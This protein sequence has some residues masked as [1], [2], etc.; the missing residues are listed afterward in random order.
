MEFPP[1]Y[2]SLN[3]YGALSRF[4][5]IIWLLRLHSPVLEQLHLLRQH[6]YNVSAISSKGAI[7]HSCNLYFARTGLSISQDSLNLQG[8]GW[9]V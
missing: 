2:S 1:T 5:H 6:I 8:R 9:A 7:I 4:I 3:F